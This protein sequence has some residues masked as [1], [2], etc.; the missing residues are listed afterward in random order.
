VGQGERAED[1]EAVAAKDLTRRSGGCAG[2]VTESYLLTPD[3]ES[4]QCLALLVGK[5]SHGRLNSFAV[6]RQHPR[7]DMVSLGQLTNAL[8]KF[9]D[10]ARIDDH[11]R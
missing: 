9:A 5:F 7:V 8:G 3:P 1:R 10:P 6:S 2:K 11:H 4:T